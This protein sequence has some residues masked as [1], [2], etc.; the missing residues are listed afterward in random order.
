MTAGILFLADEARRLRDV[1]Q[2]CP[3]H[4]D[5]VG[6]PVRRC[7]L[8]NNNKS[9]PAQTVA[10]PA[11]SATFIVIANFSSVFKNKCK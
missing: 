6:L 4:R 1:E 9:R 10:A 3:R 8:R 5:P 2:S 11:N 7:N